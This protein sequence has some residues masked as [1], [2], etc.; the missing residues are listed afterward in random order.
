[1]VEKAPTLLKLSG[2]V[3]VVKETK[4]EEVAAGVPKGMKIS[5]RVVI[6]LTDETKVTMTRDT[7]PFDGM[8]TGDTVE[9]AITAPQT[10]LA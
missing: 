8:L 3:N 6:Q 10:K 9:V 5:H 7:E 1:M 4:T 2:V